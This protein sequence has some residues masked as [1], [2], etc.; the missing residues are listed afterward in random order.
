MNK[1]DQ[2]AAEQKGRKSIMS[3][4][5]AKEWENREAIYWGIRQGFYN[6]EM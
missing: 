2:G 6:G 3:T 1:S 5:G 4:K